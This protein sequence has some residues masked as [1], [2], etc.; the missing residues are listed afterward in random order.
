MGTHKK[1]LVMALLLMMSFSSLLQAAENLSVISKNRLKAVFKGAVV[2]PKSGD[3]LTVSEQAIPNIDSKEVTELPAQ[4]RFTE[5]DARLVRS[6]GKQYLV[7]LWNAETDATEVP[8]GGA[9]IL[10]VFPVHSDKALDVVSVKADRFTFFGEQM[11]PRLGNHETFI[12]GNSH[13]NSSQGYLISSLFHIHR[14][15][16]QQIDAVF[17]LS[18]HGLCESFSEV[19]SWKSLKHRGSVYPPFIATV[20][21]VAKSE[22]SDDESCAKQKPVHSRVFTKTYRWNKRQQR[23]EGDNK[24]FDMLEKFNEKNL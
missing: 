24:E 21:L 19:L 1:T 20:N 10:A 17:T 22:N 6:D 15:K 3:I 11:P 7:T 8:G 23:Y 13:H 16:L 12:I 14:G 2:E 18:A 4:S 9:A 5:F